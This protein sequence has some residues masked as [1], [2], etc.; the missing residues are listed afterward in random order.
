[1][2]FDS[3]AAS[4]DA[5]FGVSPAGRLFR[6]RLTERV[7]VSTPPRARILDL[8]CGTGEDALWLSSQGFAVHG[9]DE[10]QG[11][12]HAARS[13]AARFQSAATF[14]CRSIESLRPSDSGYDVVISNFGALNC[15][16]LA[17]WSAILPRL[18]KA[19]GRALVVLM[20]REPFPEGLRLG[21][22]VADRGPVADVSVGST[23]L[24]V[25]YAHPS[26][27]RKAL[28]STSVVDRVEPLGFLV[29][30]PGYASFPRRHPMTFATLAMA[31][32]VLRMLP[33]FR[34][35]G[36]H[37]LYEFRPR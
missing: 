14:E 15:L 7:V 28:S 36:D 18:L 37:T 12:I 29:P 4:Y 21:V 35:R 1:V 13:K 33:V 32:T 2:P 9:V 3:I 22:G 6:F 26:E 17:T 16:P 19:S 24:K 34:S 27:V 25:Y 30:G 23:Q 11:M 5:T 20:G 10:S 31:E 8:G